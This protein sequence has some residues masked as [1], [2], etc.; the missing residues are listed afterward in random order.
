MVGMVVRGMPRQELE[1][2]RGVVVRSSPKDK[3]CQAI[4]KQ[5]LFTIQTSDQPPPGRARIR[6]SRSA[7]SEVLVQILY[8]TLKSPK[9]TTRSQSSV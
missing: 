9:S 1:R 4:N 6:S 8:A 7:Q 3:T 5:S 2:Q